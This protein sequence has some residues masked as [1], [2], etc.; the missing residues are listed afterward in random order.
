M[1][2]NNEGPRPVH[3]AHLVMGLLFL[4]IVGL[5]TSL[6]TGAVPW[7]GARYFGP[8]ILVAVGLIGLAATVASSRR[9]RATTPSA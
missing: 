8:M 2:Q 4:G 5:A 1:N 7:G 9:K 3:V 6:S